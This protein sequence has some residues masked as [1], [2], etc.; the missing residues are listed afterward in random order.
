MK[1]TFPYNNVT[2]ALPWKGDL[3]KEL[4]VEFWNAKGKDATVVSENE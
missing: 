2:E 3:S 4:P 1:R